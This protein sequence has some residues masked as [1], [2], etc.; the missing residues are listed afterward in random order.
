MVLVFHR[1]GDIRT[2]VALKSDTT[3]K[4]VARRPSAAAI[5]SW[6]ASATVRAGGARRA[7]LAEDEALPVQP[8]RGQDQLPQPGAPSSTA[9]AP[10]GGAHLQVACHGLLPPNRADHLQERRRGN[11]MYELTYTIRRV[12]ARSRKRSPR[13]RRLTSQPVGST[14]GS[15]TRAGSEAGT[16]FDRSRPPRQL[17]DSALGVRPASPAQIGLGRLWLS[18]RR[19]P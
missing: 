3:Q 12:P 17:G 8:D 4:R 2:R 18:G 11:D 16:K 9:T 13:L 5:S 6:G 14:P 7:L 1:R 10:G 15:D 19:A